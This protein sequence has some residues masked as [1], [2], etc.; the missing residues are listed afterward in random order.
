MRG[1]KQFKSIKI[2]LAVIFVLSAIMVWSVVLSMSF[3]GVVISGGQTYN[4]YS[5][6]EGGYDDIDLVLN[7]YC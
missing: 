3:S 6:Q 1:F 5:D 7:E 2:K 4:P